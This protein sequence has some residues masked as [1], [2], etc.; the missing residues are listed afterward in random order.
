MADP[1]HDDRSPFAIAAAWSANIMTICLEMVVP[2]VLGYWADVWLGTRLVFV[3]LG[4]LAGMALGTLHLVRLVSPKKDSGE[5]SP[6]TN[7]T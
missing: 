3:I 5:E 6:P 4:A 2:I 7:R 1:S